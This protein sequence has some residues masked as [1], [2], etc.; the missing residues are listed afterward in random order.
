MKSSKFSRREWYEI[1]GQ[2]AKAQLDFPEGIGVSRV[3]AAKHK[4]VGITPLWEVPP[5]KLNEIIEEC[6]KTYKKMKK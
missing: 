4:L 2:Y 6:R 3:L 1:I 5:D